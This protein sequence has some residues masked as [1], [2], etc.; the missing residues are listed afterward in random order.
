M[1]AYTRACNYHPSRIVVETSQ[2]LPRCAG[3]Q[4]SSYTIVHNSND[5]AEHEKSKTAE[6]GDKNKTYDGLSGAQG[7][8]EL[9]HNKQQEFSSMDGGQ[10]V[11]LGKEEIFC[12]KQPG[13]THENTYQRE[14]I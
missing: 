4:L 8:E 7:E 11:T 5:A 6:C 9:G 3:E 2:R 10:E 12:Q 14:A 1:D 13:S